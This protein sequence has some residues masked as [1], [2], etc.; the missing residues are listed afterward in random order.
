MNTTKNE[1]WKIYFKDPDYSKYAE[2]ALAK[3]FKTL[4]ILKDTDRSYVAVVEIAGEKLVYKEPR[5]KNRRKWQR[6]VN[7]F[8]GSDSLRNLKNMQKLEKLGIPSTKGIMALEK[9]QDFR[10]TDSSLL[11][12]YLPGNKPGKG[13]YED[14]IKILKNMHDKGILHGDSQLANFIEN[15][16]KIYVIDNKPVRNIYGKIGSMYEFIY[17]EE[18]CAEIGEYLGEIK[19]TWQY[20]VAKGFNSY[21]HFWGRVRKR[22]KNKK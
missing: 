10:V 7:F 16:G 13:Q 1:K 18:S 2:L 15:N 17:L 22:I 6:V 19:K 12:S 20:K 11:M 14:V 5:E 8:R 4:E 3:D 21:L 9:R